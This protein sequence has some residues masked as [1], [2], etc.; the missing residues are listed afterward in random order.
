[1]AERIF[2]PYTP[3]AASLNRNETTS[4]PQKKQDTCKI[5]QTDHGKEKQKQKVKMREM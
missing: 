1:M 5:G 4:P 3:T 2:P